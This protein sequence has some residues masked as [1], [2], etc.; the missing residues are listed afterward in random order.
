MK[1]N[2]AK[3]RA[4]ACSF[5]QYVILGSNKSR[6]MCQNAFPLSIRNKFTF[7]KILLKLKIKK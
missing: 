1:K 2:I 5:W 6:N 3:K 7:L 4:V